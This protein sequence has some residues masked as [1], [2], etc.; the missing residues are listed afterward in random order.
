[1]PENIAGEGHRWVCLAA[2][3]GVQSPFM[4]AMGCRYLRCTIC[5]IASQYATLIVN[6]CWSVR[7]Y[8]LLKFLGHGV[9]FSYG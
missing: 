8:W 9:S 6:R 5:V 1:L 3:C 4:R 7:W 2:D